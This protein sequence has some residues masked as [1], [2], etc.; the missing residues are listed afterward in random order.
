LRKLQLRADAARLAMRRVAPRALLLVSGRARPERARPLGRAPGCVRN[1]PGRHSRDGSR[2]GEDAGFI[3]LHVD[4]G[5]A[6][7]DAEFYKKEIR[8]SRRADGGYRREAGGG[9]IPR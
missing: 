3:C 2:P 6:F 8:G 4:D 7:G 5:L 1:W 9:E